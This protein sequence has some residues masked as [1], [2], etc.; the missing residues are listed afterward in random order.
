MNG[1]TPTSSLGAHLGRTDIADRLGRPWLAQHIA[2]V[3]HGPLFAWAHSCVRGKNA[4]LAPVAQNAL[5]TVRAP[6][7]PRHLGGLL[8]HPPAAD[9]ARW[10]RTP[11]CP[12]GGAGFVGAAS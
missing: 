4:G 12:N 8:P 1:T 5:W 11:A 7:R 3:T 6:H 2:A 9:G 10:S